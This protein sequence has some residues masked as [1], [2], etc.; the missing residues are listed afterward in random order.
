MGV[1]I[2]IVCGEFVVDFY[3]FSPVRD[4]SLCRVLRRLSESCVE[5]K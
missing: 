1:A 4:E 5:R 2:E 3:Q